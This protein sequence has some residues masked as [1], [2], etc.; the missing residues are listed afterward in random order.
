MEVFQSEG[1]A[2]VDREELKMMARGA[3]IE[4]A[5]ECSI[6]AD[7]ESGPGEVS[8]GIQERR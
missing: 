5:V 6:V 2:P 7:K 8:G 1:R 3:E 4:A